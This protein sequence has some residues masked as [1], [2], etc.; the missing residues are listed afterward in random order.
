MEVR[1]AIDDLHS[2][3]EHIT[4]EDEL[5][6]V[7]ADRLTGLRQSYRCHRSLFTPPDIEFF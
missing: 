4:A 2:S 7:I 6:A 3:L 1:R 5:L